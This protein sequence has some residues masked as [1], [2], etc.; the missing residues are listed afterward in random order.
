MEYHTLGGQ[1]IDLESQEFRLP[2]G[3]VGLKSVSPPVLLI[4]KRESE[5]L[6]GE[7]VVLSVH[8]E[9]VAEIVLR[10]I[11]HCEPETRRA[12]LVRGERMWRLLKVLAEVGC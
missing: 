8:T 2:L 5:A 1:V 9:W 11:P 7:E 10:Q 12:R 6:G 3:L 4:R